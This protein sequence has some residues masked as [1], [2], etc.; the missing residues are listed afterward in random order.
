AKLSLRDGT[1]VTLTTQTLYPHDGQVQITV[2]PA[3]KKKSFTLKL[4]V[5][6][7]CHSSSLR[8]NGKTLTAK[9]EP[10]GYVA[11]ARKWSL[12]DR[13]ELQ[14]KLEPRV[15]VGDHKNTGK[16]AVLY[17]P[18]VLAADEALLA[19]E[20]LRLS[21]IAP[22][23]AELTS[24]NLTPEPAPTA[25][26]S[27]PGAQVFRINAV[28]RRT[29]DSLKAG[30]PLQIRLIPFADAGSTGS[31]YKVWL[32]LSQPS[33]SANLLFDTQESRS[34]PGN[35]NGSISDEDFQSLVVTFNNQSANED[36][37]AVTLETPV[38]VNRVLFAHGKTFHDGGW[39]D[40]SAGKPRLQ[41]QLTKGGAWET[42]GD[43]NDYPLTTAT[44]SAKLKDGARFTC[45]LAKPIQVVGIRVIGKPA[46]GDNPQQAFA[47][48]AELQAFGQ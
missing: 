40:A 11:L 33:V 30:S 34:R 26:Q 13:I 42:V 5:P 4:R 31:A 1:P 29:T 8:L 3:A 41:V 36:W 9:P 37:F 2:D 38:T 23:G 22:A 28:A 10:D 21:S 6:A 47:S 25:L 44:D 32:P 7:W 12:G 27:W 43:F 39:F 24:L 15:I 20:N 17:G 35:L 48:C 46:C 45:Q 18:L 16:V 14:L 19:S